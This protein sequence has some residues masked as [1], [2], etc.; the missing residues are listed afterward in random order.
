MER[1]IELDGGDHGPKALQLISDLW[2]DE[3]KREVEETATALNYCKKIWDV[4]EKIIGPYQT[5]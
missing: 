1:H 4:I 2:K 5:F 3:K